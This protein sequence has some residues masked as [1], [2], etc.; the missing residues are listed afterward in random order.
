[1][2]LQPLDFG[3]LLG[4]VPTTVVRTDP[5]SAGRLE[6]R[7]ERNRDVLVSLLLPTDLVGPGGSRV[8]LTFGAGDAGWSPTLSIDAQFAFDPSVAQSFILPGNGRASIYLGGTASPPPQPTAGI[9]TATI[10]LTVSYLGN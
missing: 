5:L 9:Y 10:T 3:T 6:L 4:G 7:G 1:M 2:G 8:P